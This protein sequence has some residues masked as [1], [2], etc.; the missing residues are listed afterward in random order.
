MGNRYCLILVRPNGSELRWWSAEGEDKAKFFDRL[1]EP[2]T[3]WEV[4]DLKIEEVATTT[5]AGLVARKLE[6][7]VAKL[8]GKPWTIE[9]T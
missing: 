5:S 6:K 9:T 1:L 7:R 8:K 3:F 4:F 2:E